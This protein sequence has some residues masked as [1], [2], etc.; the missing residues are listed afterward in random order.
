MLSNLKSFYIIGIGGISMS[1]IAQ[2]LKNQGYEIYGADAVKSEMTDFLKSKNI[3]VLIG[4]APN[5][6]E[7]CDAVIKTGAISEDNS[8]LVLAR[9]LN[10]P[11]FSRAEILRE[12]TKNYNLISVAGTHGKTTTTGMIASILLHAGIDPTIHIGGILNNINSNLYIG[13]SNVFVTEACEYKDSF[14]YLNSNTSLILNIQ[15][16]HLDYFENLDKIFVSFNKFI[17]NTSKDGNII[18][19]FDDYDNRLILPENAISFGIKDGSIVQAKNIEEY[20]NGKYSFDLFFKGEFQQRIDL[21][22]LGKHNIYNALASSACALSMEIDSIKIK[23]G[24]AKFKGIKRRNEIIYDNGRNLIIHDYAHHPS[25]I[26]ASIKALREV[27]KS[28]KLIVI[29]QPH[30][31]TR[32]KALFNEFLTCFN[33]CDEV[34]F[35]PIYPAREKPIEGI[36]SEFLSLK[37]NENG[38]KSQY[39]CDFESCKQEILN[40]MDSTDVFA[41]LGAGDIELLAYSFKELVF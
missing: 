15:E 21:P 2:I 27:C 4:N 26:K 35:L 1:A 28:G 24:I 16:D 17:E 39:F 33:E 40:N 23:E 29:F 19:N 30:T 6:V 3:E 37:I 18:Y 31:F 32:T 13:K 20:E 10:K 25:E 8:D 11:I 38:K 5:F 7:K 14:L 9:K 34:W 22:C 12:I 36:T 41:I